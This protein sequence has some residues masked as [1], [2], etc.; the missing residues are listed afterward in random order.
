MLHVTVTKVPPARLV[1][2]VERVRHALGRVHQR[3][4]PAPIAVLEKIIGTWIAQG[5][6][7]AAELKLADALAD[8]PLTIDELS[9]KVGADPDAL[10]RLLRALIGEGIFT[11][12]RDG[13][14]ALNAHG[15]ALKS[16]AVV[17]VAGMARWVGL[18]EH[19][20]HWS[21]LVDAIRTGEAVVPRLRGKSGFEYLAEHPHLAAVFNDAMTSMSEA[22]IAPLI[23]AYDCTPYPTI[24]DVGGGRG[25]LLAAILGASPASRGILY[26]LPE[27]VETAPPLLRTHGVANRV[28]IVPGSFFD[29]VPAGGDLYISKNVVHDWPD[30]QAI[31]ILGNIRA[32]A[33]AGSKLLLVEL[34]LPAHSRGFIGNWI[35]M[36]MLLVAGAR[37]RTAAE[38]GALLERSGYRLTRVIPTASPLSLVEAEAV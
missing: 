12:R 38:Y 17:S 3:S 35:D 16:D 21:R 23:A 5:I 30:D 36:E 32:A 6:A 11:R 24:I 1:R 34:V 22:S 14:Y 26:D 20:E 13:R 18:P 28:D 25:R 7:V 4:V 29:S 2:V 31:A 9:R 15:A 19:R 33:A 10:A 27:V 8:G 37:E